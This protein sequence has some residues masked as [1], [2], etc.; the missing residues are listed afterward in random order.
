MDCND[1]YVCMYALQCHEDLCERL[2]GGHPPG[3]GAAHG[4]TSQAE[5]RDGHH[6]VGGMLCNHQFYADKLSH[7]FSNLAKQLVILS[8]RI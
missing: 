6:C 7:L 3:R 8:D 5:A 1:L 4:H 2:L